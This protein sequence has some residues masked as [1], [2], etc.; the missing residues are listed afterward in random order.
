LGP[1]QFHRQQARLRAQIRIRE[2]RAQPVDRIAMTLD[3]EST[4]L[5]MMVPHRVF[6]VRAVA[7]VLV[8]G[9]ALT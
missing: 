9:R 8:L 7:F 1:E 4:E 2:G 3:A 5:D 6:D